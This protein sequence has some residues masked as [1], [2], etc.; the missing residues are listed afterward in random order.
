[1]DG[2]KGLYKGMFVSILIYGGK[3]L[4]LYEDNKSKVRDV[5]MKLIF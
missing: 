1:M 5:K 4:M 2:V 3:I